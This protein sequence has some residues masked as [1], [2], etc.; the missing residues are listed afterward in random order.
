M[1]DDDDFATE[2]RQLRNHGLAGRDS[3]VR[4]GCNSRLDSIQAVVGNWLINQVD[5][6]TNT[7]IGN[8]AYLDR[9]LSRIPGIKLPQR[10]NNRKL[11]FHLYIVFADRRDELVAHCKSKGIE[12]KVH[13]P[14]PLYQQ[15]GL[16]QY[17]YK[18]GDFPVTDRHA[19][20]MISFPAHEHLTEEQL[21]YTVQTVEEFYGA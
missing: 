18:K 10:F 12:V 4:M 11:V 14:V 5:F 20:T 6:I 21:A 19:A 3:V 2:L 13:Y 7:R 15:E 16:R 8:A 1:T 9:G 17:G